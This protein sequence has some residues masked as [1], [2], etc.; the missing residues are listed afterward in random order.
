MYVIIRLILSF[1]VE[2]GLELRVY[3]FSY[4][5]NPFFLKGLD[6]YL[7]GLALNCNPPDLC[8]LSS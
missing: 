1:F 4:S 6:N 7:P 8:L 2:L 3:T 5:T